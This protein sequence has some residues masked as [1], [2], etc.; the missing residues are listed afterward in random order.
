MRD[1]LLSRG[2]SE[3]R[4]LLE[5]GSGNTKENIE[6]TKAVLAE[7]LGAPSS[8]DA[9][10]LALRIGVVTNDF[11]VFRACAIARR[12]GFTHVSPVPAGSTAL[13]LPNNMLREF[14]GIVKDRLAGNL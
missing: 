11:H 1:Y 3:D 10:V 4:I 8:E 14:L 12:A 7:A 5:A 6:F 9:S 2:I 13:F